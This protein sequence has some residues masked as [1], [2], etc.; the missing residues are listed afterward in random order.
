MALLVVHPGLSTTVQDL[1]RPGHRSR[2]VPP[3]GAFDRGA[4]AAANALL[5]NPPGAAALE[6][7]LLGGTYEARAPLALALAGAP[8]PAAIEGPDGRRDAL[9]T[10]GSFALRTGERLTLG[11]AA[12][13]ARAYLAVLGGFR[14]PPVLGSRSSESPL[15]AGDLLPADPGRCPRRSLGP[16]D[17]LEPAP[18]P[19]RILDGPDARPG[20]P[21]PDEG[22]TFRVG[23]LADRMGLRLEGEPLA[24]D[25]PAA[26]PDRPS[27]PVAP[28]A[29]QVVDGR[30]LVL[31]VACGTMGGYPHAAQVI[32]ADL[33]RL[34]QLRPGDPV[35]FHLVTLLEARCLDLA[36]RLSLS[37]LAL[38]LATAASD[39]LTFS[40]ETDLP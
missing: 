36:H 13:G 15:R 11:V 39:P 29:V 12:R 8:M 33:D 4:L 32:S 20:R 5:G 30:P 27:S 23:P 38:R 34:A 7:T 1:G 14:T 28:G 19:L 3:A 37:R 24:W 17:P 9:R 26:D 31:G 16:S 35:S 21:W 18:G 6:L 25:G 40:P 22:R 10:P 2:G